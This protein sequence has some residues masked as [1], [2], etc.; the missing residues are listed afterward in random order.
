VNILQTKKKT[1]IVLS[2]QKKSVDNVKI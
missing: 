2:F 1:I